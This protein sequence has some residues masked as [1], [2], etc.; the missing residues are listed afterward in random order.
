MQNSTGVAQ[1]EIFLRGVV[2]GDAGD[3]GVAG[4]AG[5]FRGAAACL[6]YGAE[7]P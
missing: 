2:A 1:G 3:A 4:D 6:C 7:D 5:G